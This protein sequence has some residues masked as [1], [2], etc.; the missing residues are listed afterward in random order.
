M[1]KAVKKKKVVYIVEMKYEYDGYNGYEH[2]DSIT[3]VV[4]ARNADYAKKKAKRVGVPN[5]YLFSL[6]VRP[7]LLIE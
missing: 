1:K 5:G 3:Y 2:K 4:S 7:C 6:Y